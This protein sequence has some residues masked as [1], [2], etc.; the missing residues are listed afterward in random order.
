MDCKNGF[1]DIAMRLPRRAA[2]P[3]G[4]AIMVCCLAATAQAQTKDPIKVGIFL[5]MTGGAATI[6]E[7]SKF[8]VDLAVA[9]INRTG[10]IAGRQ[11]TTILADTQTDP[12]IGVGEMKRLVEQE[13]VDAVV[14]PVISQVLLATLPILNQSKTLSLSAVGAEQVTPEAAPYGFSILINAQAQAQAMVRQAGR[15]G[16]K[17]AAIL[18]DTGAQAKSFVEALK[19]EAASKNVNI[20]AA[21]EFQYRA[22]DMTPQLVALRRANPDHLFVFSS[23]GEDAGNTL[24]SASELGWDIPMTGNYSFGGFAQGAVKIAG[25]DAFKKT[26]GINYQAFTFCG[27]GENPKAF[28]DFVGKARAANATTAGRVSL[29][30]AS[31]F[32]DN[33]YLLKAAVEGSS[34][35]TDGPTLA[36][37]L[38]QN[39]KNFKGISSNLSASEKS[40]FFIGLDNLAIVKPEK[41]RDGVFQQRV[42]CQ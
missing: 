40:H 17:N 42:D 38:E 3:I 34:G 16:A 39:S 37:W 33:V 10:G 24:K 21:Q 8:G 19:R 14:G 4:A 26:T 12:T 7:A 23:T 29:P 5:D 2:V 13:K 6:A 32:Y 1:L 18:S 41:L 25:V 27:E 28:A 22:V 36:K 9:E 15:V 31:F 35:K 20:V 30:V 11:I